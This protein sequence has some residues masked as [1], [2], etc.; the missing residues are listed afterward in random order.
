[1]AR[2]VFWIKKTLKNEDSGIC[3]SYEKPERVEPFGSM[4]REARE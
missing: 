4:I 3:K 2:S 1:V